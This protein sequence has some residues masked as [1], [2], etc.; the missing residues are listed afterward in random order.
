METNM[1]DIDP[2]DGLKLIDCDAHF[3]EPPELWTSRAPASMMDR[4]PVQKTIDGRTAWHLDGEVWASTGGNTIQ[5]GQQKVLGSHVVQPFDAIDP[6]A[7]AVKERLELCDEMGI[8]GQILYPN[9]VGFASNHIFAIED[10]AQRRAILE[11]YN[12][13]FVDVQEEGNGRLFPQAMLPIWDM[14][15][16]VA[17]MERLLDKGMTGFTLSDKPEMVGLPELWEPYYEPMWDTFNESGAVANFHIGSGMSRAE[18]ENIR[19]ARA[20]GQVGGEVGPEQL[21]RPIPAVASTWWG[22]FGHQRRLAIHAT[23]MYMSNVRIIAN[24]CLSNMFDRYP[25]LKI[26][27]AESGIGWI[28]FILEALDYQFDEMITNADEVAH[29]QRR[30]S[31]YFRDHISVMFWFEKSGPAKLIED[32]GVNNVLIETDVPHPTCLFPSTREH[33]ATVLADVD[34]HVRQRVV[35]DNAAELYGIEI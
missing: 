5:T 4:V 22:E 33:F 31:E 7:W 23:Q 32:I 13:F 21:P 17:E 1:A 16:T 6:S 20:K 14:E 18:M 19:G 15:F 10:L 12:D 30:P 25:K 3:T 24:L 8:H 27:S 29:S 34:P 28:P 9:G 2:L 26:V 35:Q 11:M